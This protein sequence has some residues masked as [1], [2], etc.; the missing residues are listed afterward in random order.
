MRERAYADS[1]M[2]YFT[3]PA[4]R[5]PGFSE[6][7]RC[8]HGINLGLFALLEHLSCVNPLVPSGEDDSLALKQKVSVENIFSKEFN[9]H[10]PDAKW[11][12]GE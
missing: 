5:T 7:V 4:S 3:A 10:D 1:I 12:S 6:A 2:R 11:I 8:Q 9:V